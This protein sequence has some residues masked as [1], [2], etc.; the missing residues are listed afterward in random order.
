MF[1]P[2]ILPKFVFAAFSCLPYST[3]F[4]MGDNESKSII[5]LVSSGICRI[6]CDSF[7]SLNAQYTCGK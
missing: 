1:T 6:G 5:S 3:R 7:K 4:I 2:L